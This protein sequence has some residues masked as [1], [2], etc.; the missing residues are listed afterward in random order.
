[1]SIMKRLVSRLGRSVKPSRKEAN[2][3]PRVLLVPFSQQNLQTYRNK[4]GGERFL[5][6]R[7]KERKRGEISTSRTRQ[8][9]TACVPKHT[10]AFRMRN[11]ARASQTLTLRRKRR[12][13]AFLGYRCYE[14]PSAPSPLSGP[15]EKFG[16]TK[17]VKQTIQ[18]YARVKPLGRRQAQGVGGGKNNP[19][20][21]W[22]WRKLE[23]P[24]ASYWGRQNGGGVI[25]VCVSH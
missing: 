21:G 8:Q 15:W 5:Q 13:V 22:E 24:R 17:M 23:G 2:E 14:G 3:R 12:W 18:I 20:E 19:S 1:M 9:N 7:E 4:P 11:A 10:R 25:S 16:L 6:A